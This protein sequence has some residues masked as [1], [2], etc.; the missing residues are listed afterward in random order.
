M[1]SLVFLFL[2]PATSFASL[3]AIKYQSVNCKFLKNGEVKKEINAPLMKISIE[4]HLGRF[5]QLHFD[6]EQRRI[7]YQ[8]L[9]EDHFSQTQTEQLLVLQNLKVGEVESSFEFVAHELNWTKISQGE[10]QVQCELNL[11]FDS[12]KN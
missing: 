8:I 1:K 12:E 7:Q 10:V 3:S 11:N 5:A 9:I 2:F 4:A 6:D